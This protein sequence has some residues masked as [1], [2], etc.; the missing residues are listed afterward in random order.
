MPHRRSTVASACVGVVALAVTGQGQSPNVGWQRFQ[1]DELRLSA[2]DVDEATSG[3]I[4]AASPEPGRPHELVAAGAVVVRGRTSDLVRAAE[5]VDGFVRGH[6]VHQVGRFS[7]TPTLDDLA[8]LTFD[9]GE[10]APLRHCRPASCA[11]KLGLDM[12]ARFAGEVP[13]SSP[14]WRARA[15]SSF[16]ASLVARA[17]ACAAGDPSAWPEYV[18]RPV[19]VR[20]AAETADLVASS[21]LLSAVP[22]AMRP[23]AGPASAAS[24]EV[25]HVRYWTREAF[26]FKPTITLVDLAVRRPATLGDAVLLVATQFYA[27]HYFEAS[28]A[29]TVGVEEPTASG[30]SLRLLF[31][32]KA[33]VDAL[34]GGGSWLARWSVGR[35]IRQRVSDTLRL[36]R[37]RV[38]ASA[39]TSMAGRAARPR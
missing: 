18:D 12:L 20:L 11:F 34:R 33:R 25:R 1:R 5:D 17:A 15:A 39:R 3:R 6:W 37:E 36:Q 38:E 8:V 28:V 4:A 30:P 23:C 27:S 26:G 31:L 10:L 9:D 16:K 29:V 7:E 22:A 13:W 24:D 21:A 32:Q 35:R 19:A 2:A 14:D